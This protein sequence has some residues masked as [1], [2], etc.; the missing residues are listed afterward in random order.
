MPILKISNG[1]CM[2][3]Y[4]GNNESL[5]RKVERQLENAI[6]EKKFL[7]N[8]KLPSQEELCKSLGVGR[9][10]LREAIRSLASRG[11]LDVRRGSGMFVS[12]FSVKDAVSSVNYFLELHSDK[13]SLYKIIKLR[14]MF[15]PQI[16]ESACKNIQEDVLQELK[17][18]L[19]D[20]ENCSEDDLEHE[21]EIDN[22]FH[23]LIA[24][25]CGNFAVSLIMEPI[26]NIIPRFH[27]IIFGKTK[28]LKKITIEYHY[29]IFKAIESR[30]SNLAKELMEKHLLET[31]NNFLNFYHP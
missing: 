28:G 9:N 10:I 19:I 4:I 26:Y 24:K 30:D 31:E 14:Q 12:D 22:R 15:E 11:L 5:T 13:E 27:P 6:R 1:E 7:P 8:E 2:F 25:G 29:S 23:S 18:T 16:V 20:M 3:S 17:Q 21:S